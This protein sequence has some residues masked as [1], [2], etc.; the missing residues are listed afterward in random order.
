MPIKA[1]L[2]DLDDTLYDHQC[3]S[4][5]GLTAVRDRYAC[6][7]QT[8]FEALEHDHDYWLEHFHVRHLSGELTL[9]EVR[10]ERFHKL[11]TTYGDPVPRSTAEEAVTIYREAYLA[12][13]RCVPGTIPLLEQL[14][15]QGIKIG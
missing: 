1:V 11:L 7:Q 14:R 2:F 5:S 10:V 13:E 9:N 6:F 4:R 15:E 3:G 8:P 12:A